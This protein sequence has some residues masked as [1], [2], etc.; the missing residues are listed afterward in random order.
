MKAPYVIGIYIDCNG[1]E[2]VKRGSLLIVF[3]GLLILFQ[4]FT[5]PEFP[6]RNINTV[7]MDKE[8]GRYIPT[9]PFLPVSEFTHDGRVGLLRKSGPQASV[10]LFTLKPE[11]RIYKHMKHMANKRV[12]AN[13][14]DDR[15]DLHYRPESTFP[16]NFRKN[17]IGSTFNPS[18]TILCEKTEKRQNPYPCDNGK[19]CYDLTFITRYQRQISAD[20]KKAKFASADVTIKVENP[21]TSRAKIVS[22]SPI[23]NSFKVS[24]L[25][26]YPKLAEPVVVGDGRLLITR[27]H[28]GEVVLSDGTPSQPN[29]NIVYSVY[30]ERFEQCDPSRWDNLHPVSHAYHDSRMRTRYKFAR[31]P[32]RDALGNL[33]PDG[34]DI[35]GSY[36]WMD[37]EAANLFFSSM[38]TDVFYNFKR[39]YVQ[40]P[41]EEASWSSYFTP[42]GLNNINDFR[43]TVSYVE[44]RGARTAGIAV[45]GFWTH[46]KTVLLD[47]Q[48]NNAD[49]NF[50]V[51]NRIIDGKSHDVTRRLKLYNRTPSGQYFEPVGAVRELGSD[52][53]TE[54]SAYHGLL[55]NNSTFLG[56][57]ENR[58]NYIDEVK[59][60]T[61]RDL[62]WHFGTTRHMEEIVFDDFNNPFFLINA[63]MTAPVGFKENYLLGYGAQY[64]RHFSGF[65]NGVE[66]SSD[67]SGDPR[68]NGAPALVQNSATAPNTFMQIPSYGKISGPARIEPIA[69][70]GVHGKGLWLTEDSGVHFE[71]PSQVGSRFSISS[72]KNWYIG[73]FFDSRRSTKKG[74]THRL[75][76]W[77]SRYSIALKKVSDGGFQYDRLSLLDYNKPIAYRHLPTLL[78]FNYKRWRHLGIQFLGNSAP[79]VFID[80]MKLGDL[81]TIKGVSS[82]LVKNAFRL[83]T[84]DEV[85]LGSNGEGMP[86][87]R[88][89]VDDFKVIARAPTWEEKC[90]YARGTLIELGSSNTSL[91]SKAR[92]YPNDVHQGM[93]NILAE[94]D[95]NKKYLC[96]QRIYGGQNIGSMMRQDQHANLK[97]IPNGAKS[98]RESVLGIKNVLVFN[99]PRPDFSKNGFCLSCHVSPSL[100]PNSELNLMA[101][102]PNAFKVQDDLRRQP[103]EPDAIIRG[104]IP[105]GYFGSRMPASEMRT[106]GARIDQWIHPEL[107]NVKVVWNRKAS[108]YH[109][110]LDV[111][112]T[113]GHNK[114]V[115]APCAHAGI[116]KNNNSYTLNG[117]CR[118]KNS[119]T[120][121]MDINTEV[122]ICSAANGQWKSGRVACSPYKKLTEHDNNQ[123][124]I[125]VQHK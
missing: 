34:Y 85:V 79:K 93:R 10:P 32:L 124:N 1:G 66:Q 101:L 13:M 53:G 35:G 84:G 72:N 77:G 76:S 15:A 56:S 114:F 87:V 57:L 68:D 80:G 24:R 27:V 55:A 67:F 52:P 78:R 125:F 99:K 71:I 103:L 120:F 118:N 49:Y 98:V 28:N 112:V 36:P 16:S 17:Q 117:S 107:K 83:S 86:G 4:N 88:G 3:F 6:A 100:N 33:I 54:F 58:L 81:I 37:M 90:N 46:G 26:E 63:E 22:I 96:F 39:N 109:Y 45:A 41:F 94:G 7:V 12:G 82:A 23:S 91:L 104:V 42:K 75:L 30:P 111:R 40:T 29:I 106:L 38:G 25:Y 44:A 105:A 116:L 97:N 43:E 2:M 70:G 113:R 122:R 123:L 5:V 89:W 9:T 115:Y 21:K 11:G 62:V 50:R 61:P 59:P 51:S 108:H 60:V 73:V 69:K 64:M 31:Y 95:T 14:I 47:G 121:P 19:D 65:L 18:R 20:H 8:G 74:N 119:N 110:S 92:A 102:L 48:I